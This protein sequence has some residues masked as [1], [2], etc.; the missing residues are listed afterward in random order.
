MSKPN[1]LT[2]WLKPVSSASLN[3]SKLPASQITK[4]KR[5]SIT[6]PIEPP[7]QEY[8]EEEPSKKQKTTKKAPAKI[9]PAKKTPAKKAAEGNKAATQL[10]KKVIDEVDKKA[11][12]LD[13]RVKKMS[14]NSAAITSDNYS[15][16]MMNNVKDVRKLMAMGQDGAKLAFNAVLH[17]GPRTHG[18][19]D[20]SWKMSGYGGHKQPFAELDQLML[21]IVALRED[22]DCSEEQEDQKLPTVKHHWTHADADVGEFKTGRPNKQQRGQIAR[23]KAAW[24]KE[25]FAAARERREK[26]KDWVSNAIE[27]L[28]VEQAEISGYGLDGYFK[29]SIVILEQLKSG[30]SVVAQKEEN[31]E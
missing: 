23:Q 19:L 8:E 26:V 9:I 25:R 30:G 2:A 14:P 20:A 12:G 28:K 15:G 18:D 29:K 13:A 7:E 1:T 17:M 11:A 21:E 4:R 27:E 16:A 3:A 22:A 6:L 5:T 10:Y 31:N 24:M